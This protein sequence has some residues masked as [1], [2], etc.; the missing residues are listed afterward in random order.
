V[1]ADE[2]DQFWKECSVNCSVCGGECVANDHPGV[3]WHVRPETA[4]RERQRSEDRVREA[5]QHAQN[6]AKERRGEKAA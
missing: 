2:R 5:V 1:G 3:P 6:L 4:E